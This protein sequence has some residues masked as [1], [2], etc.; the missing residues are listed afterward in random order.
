MDFI[1]ITYQQLQEN[2]YLSE[3]NDKYGLAAFVDDNI[4][5]TFLNNPNNDDNSKT[6]ILFAVDNN[7]I[8]GRHLLYG[9]SLKYKDE[10]YNA[11]SSGSTEVHESQ[12]GKGIGSKINSYTL[13]NDEYPIYLC[14]LLS[15]SCYSIMRKKENNCTIFDFPEYVKVINTESAFAC[16]GIKG[17]PLKILKTI[18]NVAISILNIPNKLR[19]GRLKKV[20][21]IQKETKVPEWAGEMCLNDGHKYAEYHDTKWLQWCLDYNLSDHSEDI[22]SFYCIYNKQN[23]PVGFFMTKERRRLDVK[24]CRMVNGTVCEWASIDENLSETDIN[25]LALDTFSKDCYRVLTITDSPMTEKQ[26]RRMGF[27]KHGYM[28]MGFRDKLNQFPDMK[29]LSLWRIRFGCCNSILY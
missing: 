1:K 18:G 24:K 14:S 12:R 15:P 20:Y 19:I 27:I 9:T 4:R 13:N 25:L 16:R 28:Q 23:Q 5:K 26:L 22:Q 29:D 17:F 2:N 21:T 8:V 11:Q 3:Y 7:I 6:A 10:K